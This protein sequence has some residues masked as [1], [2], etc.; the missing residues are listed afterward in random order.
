MC[1]PSGSLTAPGKLRPEQSLVVSDRDSLALERDAGVM[2]L[3]AEIA[4]QSHVTMWV[5]G[6]T[7]LPTTEV[8]SADNIGV[9]Q[10]AAPE[11]LD[12]R[13]FLGTDRYARNQ[14]DSQQEKVSLHIAC[15]SSRRALIP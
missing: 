10:R 3:A 5:E 6:R 13:I 14:Q 1:K 2:I 15:R 12:S 4:Y 9:V 8:L 7:D 11:E